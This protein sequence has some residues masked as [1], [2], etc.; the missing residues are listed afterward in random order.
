[1]LNIIVIEFVS[2]LA[3]ALIAYGI[4]TFIRS[5][6]KVYLND[7][8]TKDYNGEV[9]RP[10][11]IVKEAKAVEGNKDVV[12]YTCSIYNGSGKEFVSTKDVVF[13]GKPNVW[14]IGNELELYFALQ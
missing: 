5:N 6:K 3:I 8:Y 4:V 2:L 12:E 9:K 7:K 10:L 13:Y 11:F 14:K 1:M